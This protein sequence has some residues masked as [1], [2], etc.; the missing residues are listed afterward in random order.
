MRNDIVKID[1]IDTACYRFPPHRRIVDAI[2]EVECLE[3]IAATVHTNTGDE[4]FGF[5]MEVHVHL[6][7]ATPNALFVEQVPMLERF[8]QQRLRIEDGYAVPPERPG[9]GVAFDEDKVGA[10]CLGKSSWQG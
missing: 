4:G 3:V 8:L 9:H 2:Q 6:V 7:C 1:R 10:Y 5:R